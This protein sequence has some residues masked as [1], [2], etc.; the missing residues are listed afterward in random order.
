MREIRKPLREKLLQMNDFKFFA[1][2]LSRKSTKL[3][4]FVKIYLIKVFCETKF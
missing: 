1:D 2:E 4:K 3:V